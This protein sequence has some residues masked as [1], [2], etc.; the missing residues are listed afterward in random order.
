MSIFRPYRYKNKPDLPRNAPVKNGFFV[1]WEIYFRKFWRFFTLNILYFIVTLPIL[2]YI[3]FTVNGYIQLLLQSSGITEFY[4]IFPG[5][6]FLSALIDF[7][8][9]FLYIPL[10]VLSVILYGPATMGLTYIFRNF[11]R[12]EHAWTSDFFSRGKSNFRQGLF[13]GLLD[14]VVIFLLCNGI[15]GDVI[16]GS[17]II[18]VLSYALRALSALVLVIYFF[19]RHYFYLMAVSVELSVFSIIKNAMLFVVIGFGRNLLAGLINLALFVLCFLTW[20]LA[21]VIGVPFFFYSFTGFSTVFICYPVIKKYIILPALEQSAA[22]KT[23]GNSM[24]SEARA[25]ANKSDAEL[26]TQIQ[27]PSQPES[28][29]AGDGVKLIPSEDETENGQ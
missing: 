9:E 21:T 22:Q 3:Y 17:G 5:L 29:A 4:D 28:P 27:S 1:F 13:F 26:D 14:I 19:M 20:P 24:Q 2:F 12:E 11:A 6:T 23:E 18:T 8:P 25:P 10:L 15:A 7:I 16:V